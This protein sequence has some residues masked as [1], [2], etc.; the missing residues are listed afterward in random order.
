MIIIKNAPKGM[1]LKALIEN[2]TD[3]TK[4][5]EIYDV[6]F[7]SFSYDEKSEYPSE[8]GDY[9]GV[10]IG[11]GIWWV[12]PGE[13]DYEIQVYMEVTHDKDHTNDAT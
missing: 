3:G 2:F 13:G 4:D 6:L 5:K 10:M 7:I 8:F 1:K 9:Y 12:R 11:D